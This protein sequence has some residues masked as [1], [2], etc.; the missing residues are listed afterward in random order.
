MLKITTKAHSKS[1]TL[2]AADSEQ[3]DVDL[4]IAHH[5]AKPGWAKSFNSMNFPFPVLGC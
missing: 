1:Q 3:K 4:F 5:I 2:T